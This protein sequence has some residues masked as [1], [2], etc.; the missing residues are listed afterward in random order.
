MLQDYEGKSSSIQMLLT[1][2]AMNKH[3]IL[4]TRK[5]KH[6]LLNGVSFIR[7]KKE[8]NGHT[9]NNKASSELSF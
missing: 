5:T 7:T 4:Q 2:P 8:A 3:L 6:R 1:K 9:R